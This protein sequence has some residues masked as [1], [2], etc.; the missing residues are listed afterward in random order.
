MSGVNACAMR[1]KL[2]KEKEAILENQ[3]A[4]QQ[5]VIRSAE[6][7]IYENISQCLCLARLELGSIDLDD[8]EKT[9]AFI[10]EA[11]LL[12]GKAVKDLRNLA[13]QLSLTD[14]KPKYQ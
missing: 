10:G 8:K 3:L 12:I 5:T 13:K 9:L 11:N 4:K 7:E 6:K 1:K 14:S 2:K